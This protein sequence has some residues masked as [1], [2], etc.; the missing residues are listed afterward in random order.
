M[1]NIEGPLL[2]PYKL[3]STINA[4]S[5]FINLLVSDLYDIISDRVYEMAMDLPEISLPIHLEDEELDEAISTVTSQLEILAFQ[6]LAS[7]MGI[8]I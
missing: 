3:P 8:K 2:P 5:P 4:N 7:K 6:A 1:T